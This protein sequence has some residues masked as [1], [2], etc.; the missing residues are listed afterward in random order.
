MPAAL[1]DVYISLGESGILLKQLRSQGRDGSTSGPA[2][3]I[4]LEQGQ[5]A[6]ELPMDGAGK[7]PE[8]L[9]DAVLAPFA[10]GGTP[11]D[12]DP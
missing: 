7:Y 10:P 1:T 5:P 8:V 2:P 11:L 9:P 6:E 3:A 4:G 12:H